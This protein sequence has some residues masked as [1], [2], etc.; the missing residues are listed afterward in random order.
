[1]K[2]Y[3]SGINEEIQRPGPRAESGPHVHR[4]EF[5][6]RIFCGV[7]V[8]LVSVSLLDKKRGPGRAVEKEVGS[9]AARCVTWPGGLGSFTCS[10]DGV[11]SPPAGRLFWK[12]F[13]SGDAQSPP[14]S[15]VRTSSQLTSRLSL[16]SAGS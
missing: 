8:V 14:S 2:S 15:P 9:W 12:V 1:M 7:C 13:T 6:D 5:A 4:V 10:V 11:A 16:P 3:P